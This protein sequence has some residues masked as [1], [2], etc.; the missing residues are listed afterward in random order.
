MDAAWAK[1]LTDWAQF[2]LAGLIGA[3]TALWGTL[4]KRDR[5]MAARVDAVRR[6]LDSS[7]AEVRSGIERLETLYLTRPDPKTCA[8]QMARIARMESA[9]VVA[10]SH[11]DIA[12][13]HQRM[14][15]QGEAL[16][17]I[18]GGIKRIE[19]TV[20][21]LSQYMLEHGPRAEDR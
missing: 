15:G 1:V 20:D 16:A 7:M 11:S 3:L 13:A 5:A 10:P 2:G 8:E 19:R 21:M 9:L 4:G 18:R 12:H 14:D 17:E 6:D